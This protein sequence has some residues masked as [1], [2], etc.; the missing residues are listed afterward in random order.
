[1]K[2]R[3]KTADRRVKPP[4]QGL[5]AYYTRHTPERRRAPAGAVAP[6]LEDGG[7]DVASGNMTQKPVT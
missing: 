3:R 1:M 6:G 2:D 7:N 4:K 5:P